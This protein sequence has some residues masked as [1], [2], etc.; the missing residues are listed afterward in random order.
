MKNVEKDKQL[1]ESAIE[2]AVTEIKD[3]DKEIEAFSKH[4]PML[5]KGMKKLNPESKTIKEL[6][7]NLCVEFEKLRYI[8]IEGDTSPKT[9]ELDYI[10]RDSLY[11]LQKKYPQMFSD[12][13][14]C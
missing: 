9:I 1:E 11:K 10:H 8:F 14:A 6:L 12:E 2:N 13:Q 5:L 7:E 4:V 3:Y